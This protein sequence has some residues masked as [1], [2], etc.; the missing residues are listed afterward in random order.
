MLFLGPGRLST[1]V[2]TAA[3]IGL[4][5]VVYLVLII[6]TRAI[7]LEDMS[8]IPKGEKLAKILRIK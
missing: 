3:G 4:G 5:A 1:Y 6:I 7:T 2:A 8:L